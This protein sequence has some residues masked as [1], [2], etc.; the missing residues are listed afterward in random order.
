M[1]RRLSWGNTSSSGK[2]YRFHGTTKYTEH[3]SECI[4]RSVWRSL[5]EPYQDRPLALLD[6]RSM[7]KED[8]VGADIVF[9]HYCDEGYEVLHSPHHRWFYKRG[10]SI[11]E[12]LMFK[13]YD[14]SLDGVSCKSN[15]IYTKATVA[16]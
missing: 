8:L 14:S 12:V 1:P 3:C 6:H 2:W 4:H 13:L 11:N 9:P 5:T 10:M 15:T 7:C 16:I